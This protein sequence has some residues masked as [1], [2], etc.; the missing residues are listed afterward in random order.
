MSCCVLCLF[1]TC[2]QGAAAQL[3]LPSALHMQLQM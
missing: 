2:L 1:L 3:V